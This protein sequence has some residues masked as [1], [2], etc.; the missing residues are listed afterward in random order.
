MAMI[1][2]EGLDG[3]R[4]TDNRRTIRIGDG[5]VP[6]VVAA[7]G[8][9]R[10]GR[11]NADAKAGS[12]GFADSGDEIIIAILNGTIVPSISGPA[13]FTTACAEGKHQGN[14]RIHS[15]RSHV[16]F[17]AY[18]ESG[19]RRGKKCTLTLPSINGARACFERRSS[20]P[21]RLRW[22]HERHMGPRITGIAIALIAAM[23][24]AE[25]K[26]A[27][28]RPRPAGRT[29]NFVANKT[30]GL[31]IMLGAPSGLSG[32]YFVSPSHAI[33]FGIGAVRYYRRRD[34]LHLHADYLWH[35]VSLASTRPF[36]LPL[37]FGIGGRA[38]DFDDNEF[39]DDGFAL[40][41]RA[42]LG[43]AFDFNNVPL[44]VFFELALVV[45]F[46]FDYRDEIFADLNGAIG[47]RYYFN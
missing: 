30:F 1:W 47:V 25:S 28:A 26:T 37:Y 15:R 17:E 9:R 46:L 2:H 18:G 40:G 10:R 38:F 32:K 12:A 4:C 29:S 35:P 43:V 6:G 5:Y 21:A 14:Q 34:G 36:E 23:V 39:D 45:D 3:Q 20:Q 11:R 13:R 22:Y 33:D 8:R 24:L 27:S 42:P 19:S 16:V 7:L 44:D 31:G 41:V